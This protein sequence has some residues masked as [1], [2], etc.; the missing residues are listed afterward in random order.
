MASSDSGGGQ[1]THADRHQCEKGSRK[2]TLSL[3][4]NSEGEGV[5]Q[6]D[7]TEVQRWN[8]AVRRVRLHFRIEEQLSPPKTKDDKKI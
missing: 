8:K 1:D 3:E 4:E 5:R 2:R 6:Q 7:C